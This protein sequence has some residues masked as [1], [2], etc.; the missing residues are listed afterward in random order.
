M[1]PLEPP[2]QS[3]PT[4]PESPTPASERRGATAL[5]EVATT[6]LL[7]VLLALVLRSFVAQAYEV[8]G[9]SMEPTFH[10]GEKVMVHKLAPGILPI[11]RGDIIIFA[12]PANP[13]RDLIKRVIAV[14]G[15]TVTIRAGRV[16][17]NGEGLHEDYIYAEG[18]VGGDMTCRVP[19]GHYFVLGDNRPISLDSRRFHAIP[20]S[21]VKGKV[22]LRWWP[23]SHFGIF[24]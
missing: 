4:P 6:V 16:F 3:V 10:D 7:A 2:A 1:P 23:L 21:L 20:S 11:E 8:N 14:G 19:L 15:D 9:R 24:D 18:G 22:F 12:S 5:F 17:V 13:G